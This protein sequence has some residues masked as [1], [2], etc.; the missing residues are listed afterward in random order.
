MAAS[1]INSDAAI[2][3]NFSG[4]AADIHMAFVKY[5]QGI[6]V[7]VVSLR[8]HGYSLEEIN[9][10]L[11]LKISDDSLRQWMNLYHQTRDVVCNPAFYVQRGRPLAFL[12]EESKFVLAAL[13]DNPTMYLDEIQSHIKAIT[14]TRHPLSTISAEL[15]IRLHLTRKIAR[16]VHPAQSE[17]QRAKYFEEIGPFPS[18][19]FVFVDKCVLLSRNHSRNYA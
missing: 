10:T 9:K 8:R 7:I 11:D 14:G 4:S 13:D 16:T 18:S 17:D 1:N 3:S 12:R 2:R 5:N 15:R 19:Y 6:K